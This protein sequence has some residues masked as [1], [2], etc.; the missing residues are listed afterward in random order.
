MPAR[1]DLTAESFAAGQ[2]PRGA[3]RP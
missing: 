1:A 2:H 3:L